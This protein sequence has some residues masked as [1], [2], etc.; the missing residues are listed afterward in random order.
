M[1]LISARSREIAVALC[2]LAIAPFQ[3]GAQTLLP[4]GWSSKDIG[5][6]GQPGSASGASNAFTVNG[7]GADIW[8]SSDAFHFA[9]RPWTGDGTIVAEVTAVQGAQAWT[10][11]GVMIRASTV[12]SSAHALMLVSTS[13]GAAFQ[14]RTANGG[15]STSTGTAG[16]APRWLKLARLGN[17]ISASV[18]SD[19]Q[20]WTLVGR[21]TVALPSTVLVGLAVSSHDPTRLATG[22][23]DNVTIAAP[24]VVAAPTGLG[25][26]QVAPNGRFLQQQN[27][28]RHFFYL[29]DVA[30]GLFK[31]LNRAD[32]DAYFQ[33]CVA[34][35]FTTIQAVALWN[36][37][38]GAARNVYGDHPL[39]L[40]NSRYD[41]TRVVTTPG[42]DPA[43]PVAYDYWDH[44]DYILDKAE[45]YGLYVVFE[46]T[47]GN[48]VSGTNSYAFDMSSNIFTVEN[49]KVY[50]QFLGNRY[51]HRPNLIWM[52]GGDRSA[53]YPNGDFRPVWRSMA[54]GI[55][56]GVSGQARL[57][58]QVHPAWNQLVMTYQTTRRDDP[59][60]SRWFHYDAW[61]DYNAIQAEYHNIVSRVQSDWNKLPTKPTVLVEPRFED[62]L[63]TDNIVFVGAFKQRYQMYHAV[64]AGVAGYAYG[65]KS[66]WDFVTTGKTWQAALNDPGRVSIR[67]I[68]QLLARFSDAEL[69]SRVPDQALLDGAIGSAKT[70][71][72]LIAMRG[73]DGRF[74]LVYSTNGRDIRLNRSRLAAGTADAFWFNPRNG[75]YYNSAGSLI[76]GPFAQV[77]TGP[78]TTIAVFN[79]PGAAG[80]ENDWLLE[81]RL[82]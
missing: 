35:G 55:G 38:T 73:G 67:P 36:W 19:G 5:A 80:P 7:A 64:L 2:L 9:Y 46:P 58:D 47:W 3:A 24:V 81:L 20:S 15:L 37:G 68:R 70:E 26:V 72:L 39:V 66:I 34:K 53:V 65:H 56:R 60:S 75:K 18:S 22:T 10:K 1:S 51:G 31:R 49:A 8:G 43:D 76:T 12:A 23:F 44:V 14:R 45:A 30:W 11:V 77:A 40:A 41:P 25:R 50:G 82:R 69:F 42:N 16:T 54:E 6:V 59:G 63:S 28:G 21:D 62:E 48:Y 13:K 71:D 27:T 79:P 57:W 4:S 61:L 33:D 17:V 32:V 74:A 29:A 52:L 78:G